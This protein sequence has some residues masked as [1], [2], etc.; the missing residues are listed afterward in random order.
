MQPGLAW[1]QWTH[2]RA[3][4]AQRQGCARCSEALAKT[5]PQRLK[6]ASWQLIRENSIAEIV[7]VSYGEVGWIENGF[8]NGFNAH[9]RR[10]GT[11]TA[12]VCIHEHKAPQSA[13]S[14]CSN[15]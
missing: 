7:P 15:F 5:L 10:N 13:R 3:E 6:D 2:G 12:A 9:F 8:E 14:T 1:D 11:P 4:C